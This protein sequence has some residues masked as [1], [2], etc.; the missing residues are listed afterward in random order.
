MDADQ[1]DP[2]VATGYLEVTTGSDNFAL[3][4]LLK[5]IATKQ[6]EIVSKCEVLELKQTGSGKK[7]EVLTD[8]P[9]FRRLMKRL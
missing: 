1:I 7:I 5:D 2:I 4:A 6:T 8:L 9:T 3:T